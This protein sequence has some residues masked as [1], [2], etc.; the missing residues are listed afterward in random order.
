MPCKT[1]RAKDGKLPSFVLPDYEDLDES[2]KPFI[3]LPEPTDWFETLKVTLFTLTLFPLRLLI[4]LLL[5]FIF[6]PAAVLSTIGYDGSKPA[7]LTSPLPLWRRVGFSIARF[8]GRAGLFAYGFHDLSARQ[9]SYADMKTL[10]DHSPPSDCPIE[11]DASGAEI[12]RPCHIVISNHLGFTDILYLLYFERGSF[13]AKAAMRSVPFIGA[14]CAAVQSIFVSK[15]ESTTAALMSRIKRQIDLQSVCGSCGM[16]S[17][18]LSNVIVFPEGTTTNGSDLVMF[19]RGVFNAGAAVR[20]TVISS[21]W[22]QCNTSWEAIP[23]RTLTWKVMSQCVNR[24]EVWHAPPYLPSEAEKAD[25]TLF[26]YNVNILM[27]QMLT[28]MKRDRAQRGRATWARRKGPTLRE[29]LASDLANKNKN[30]RSVEPTKIYLTNRDLKVRCFHELKLGRMGGA[31]V[32]R[33]A[34]MRCGRDELIGRYLTQLVKD[35]R[36]EFG[37]E[38]LREYREYVKDICDNAQ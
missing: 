26:A 29:M 1:I 10:F 24:L 20:L 22:S 31:E 37:E 28:A 21:A 15:D 19:R 11:Y 23:F 9:L 32:L 8:A 6:A 12:H 25:S 14:I 17:L 4:C 2:F 3:R 34:K 35:E 7:T 16:C 27:A 30:G 13:L 33:K 38:E 36:Y 5:P 18:C